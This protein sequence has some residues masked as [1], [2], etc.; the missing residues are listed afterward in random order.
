[1][2][3]QK[4]VFKVGDSLAILIPAEVCNFKTLVEGDEVILRAPEDPE[5]CFLVIKRGNDG[6]KKIKR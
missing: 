3:Y 6:R 5:T 4:R 2:D 1:M